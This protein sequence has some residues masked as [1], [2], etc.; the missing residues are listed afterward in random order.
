MTT[1]Q[2]TPAEKNIAV[3]GGYGHLGR[4][5]TDSLS[6]NGANVFVLARGHEKFKDTFGED[7]KTNNIVYVNA[8]ISSE[9]SIESAFELIKERTGGLDGLINNAYYTR[10]QSNKE[11]TRDDFNYTIDGTLS[12][13]FSCINRVIPFLSQG[14]SILNVSSI[15]GVVAPDFETYAGSPQFPN[16]PHYGAAKAGVIQLTKYY[17]SLLGPKGIRVNAISPGP[18]PSKEVQADF[19]FMKELSKRTLLGRFG[20]PEEL[21]GIFTFL[22]SDAA[23][24]ITG[25]NFIVDGGWTTT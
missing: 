20:E 19:Q 18:F 13:V 11:L 12:S 21:A 4:A 5:I 25:Q 8:D 16:P 17:A 24:Y 10:G 3:T 23:K 22:M 1:L 14:A 9:E 15:Y 6:K 2:I 7:A